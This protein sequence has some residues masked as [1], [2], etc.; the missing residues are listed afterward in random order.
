METAPKEFPETAP[1][2]EQPAPLEQAV[3][4]EIELPPPKASPILRAEGT[5]IVDSQGQQVFLKGCNLG[6]W[7]LLEM[8]ML[9]IDGIRD[10]Y[11]F[12]SILTQRFGEAEK[13]RLMELYRTNFITERDFAMVRRFGMNVVRIPFN[14]TLFED[15]AHPFKLKESGIQ[16][17]DMALDLA[18]KRGAVAQ[19]VHLDRRAGEQ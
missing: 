19:H 7:F 17:L 6:N 13:D 4:P 9:G 10:Q 8:W 18:R 14:Y 11:E 1:T 15:D 3:V 12:E 5:R 2:P 16:W